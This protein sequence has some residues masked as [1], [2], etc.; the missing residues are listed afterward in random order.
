MYTTIDFSIV[1]SLRAGLSVQQ[2]FVRRGRNV[3]INICIEGKALYTL[4]VGNA[5]SVVYISSI[6]GQ[7][8]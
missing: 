7:F 1:S 3:G 4:C 6:H 5:E 8:G 2:E